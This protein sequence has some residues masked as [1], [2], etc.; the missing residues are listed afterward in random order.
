MYH[1]DSRGQYVNAFDFDRTTGGLSNARPLLTLTEE[2]GLP[3]GAAVDGDGFY[4]SA[5]VTAGRLNKISP[6]GVL[7]D[8]IELPV[9]APT[10]PCFGGDNR[11]TIFITSLA[12]DR[13]GRREEGTLISFESDCVGAPV[14]RFGDVAAM[15]RF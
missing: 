4:W 5:G 10:M 14:G 9:A 15:V 3:D 11:R 7:V 12:S 13:F 8:S 1:A 2:Q 6:Q